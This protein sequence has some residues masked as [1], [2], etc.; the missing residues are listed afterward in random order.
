MSKRP[1]T[2]NR[3][4]DPSFLKKIKQSI[5]YKE[6]PTVETKVSFDAIFFWGDNLSVQQ[7][8]LSGP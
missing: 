4:E 5:G 2:F 1:I 7:L 6:G 8:N 3:P